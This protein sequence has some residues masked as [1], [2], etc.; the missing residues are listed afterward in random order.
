M[1]EVCGLTTEDIA[2]AYLVVLPALAQ[3][4]WGTR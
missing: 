3:P 1:R 4:S 2:R